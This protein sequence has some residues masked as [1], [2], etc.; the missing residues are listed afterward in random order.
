VVTILKLGS[1]ACVNV[2]RLIVSNFISLDGFVAGPKGELDWFTED[3]FDEGSET[4]QFM[5]DSVSSV[6][7]ILMGRLTYQE[8]VRYWPTAPDHPITRFMNS[9]PKVV[10]SRTLK[11]VDWGKWG[12]IR[13]AK[14]NVGAEV[15]GLKRQRGKD[16]VIYGSASLVS[17]LTRLRLVDE[18]R[19]ILIPVILGRGTPEFTGIHGWKKLKLLK[20]KPFKT[21]AVL[22]YYAPRAP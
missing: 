1:P 5:I 2:R 18:Y 20:A 19:I 17:E 16:I 7:A 11:R 15:R 4:L 3:A 6:G 9:L 8:F 13:L 10:F 21:G 14:G 12:N 22:L